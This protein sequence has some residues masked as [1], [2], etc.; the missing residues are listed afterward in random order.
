[1]EQGGKI[2]HTCPQLGSGEQ[3]GGSASFTLLPIPG[4]GVEGAWGTAPSPYPKQGSVWPR[5]EAGINSWYSP[6]LPSLTGVRGEGSLEPCL[7]QARNFPGLGKGLW[8][9]PCYFLSHQVGKGVAGQNS[10]VWNSCSS[11]L[12]P[13]FWSKVEEAAGQPPACFLFLGLRCDKQAEGSQTCSLCSVPGA[14]S[15]GDKAR[16]GE[17][18]PNLFAPTSFLP[19][20][21]T[22]LGGKGKLVRDTATPCGQLLVPLLASHADNSSVRSRQGDKLLP[23]AYPP[24]SGSQVEEALQQSCS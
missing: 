2:L 5:D 19:P 7:L 4:T 3:C 12:L 16:L 24:V 21:P 8:A 14:G 1:M 10:L 22:Q 13:V 9:V 11:T 20:P 6:P 15:Q 23:A 17:A 18:F